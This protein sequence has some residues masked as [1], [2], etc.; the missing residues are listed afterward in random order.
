MIAFNINIYLWHP[1]GKQEASGSW[2][3]SLLIAIAVSI[4]QVPTASPLGG[5]MT[6]T[7]AQAERGSHHAEGP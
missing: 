5:A 2:P 1:E 3:S 4:P 7:E 6:A